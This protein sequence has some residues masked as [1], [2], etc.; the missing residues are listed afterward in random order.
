MAA[1][2]MA[3]EHFNTRNAAVVPELANLDGCN[4]TLNLDSNASFF[5]TGS[6]TKL[7]SQRFF[8]RGQVPC[9]IAGPFSDLPATELSVMAQAAEAPMVAHRAY[10]YR[11]TSNFFSGFT[12][13]VYPHAMSSTRNLVRFL[14][15]KGRTNYIALLYALSDVNYQRRE[16]LSYELDDGKIEWMSS[17]Y[18]LNPL[19]GNFTTETRTPLSA[20]KHI[21]KSGYRTIVVAMDSA[22]GELQAIADA[23]EA[24]GMNEGNYFWVWYDVFEPTLLS[25][26]NTNITKMVSGSVWMLPLPLSIL[27]PDDPFTLAWGSQGKEEVDR[28][29]ANN[30]IFPGNPGYRFA[31]DGFF[32]S[33]GQEYGSGECAAA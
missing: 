23:A 27:N 33:V 16:M 18:Y 25:F 1:A 21:Q 22:W 10:N 9:A 31:T 30:P 15:D 2:L 13:Q 3:A 20:L 28:L 24:L 12:S 32:Q 4:I 11:T 7:A 29:N 26:G 5:D 8:R 6:L 19:G 17:A 14:L